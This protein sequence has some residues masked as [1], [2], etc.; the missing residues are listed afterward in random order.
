MNGT[1]TKSQVAIGSVDTA[2]QVVGVADFD[3]DSKADIVWRKSDG[4]VAMWLMNGATPA[5]QAVVGTVDTA[6]Q[7]VSTGRLRR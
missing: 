4:T 6:W 3:G 5:T 1:T 7:V 2:W